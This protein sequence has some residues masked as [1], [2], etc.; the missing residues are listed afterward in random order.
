[1]IPHGLKSRGVVAPV[2]GERVPRRQVQRKTPGAGSSS[3]AK[4]CRYAIGHRDGKVDETG[5]DFVRLVGHSGGQ[6]L[7]R[8]LFLEVIDFF[9]GTSRQLIRNEHLLNGR[10]QQLRH[11][12]GSLP[13]LSRHRKTI[14]SPA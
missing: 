11:V 14:I 13:A 9:C 6:V 10:R 7:K 5:E 4:P 12:H 3:K 8:Q 2:N 1:M